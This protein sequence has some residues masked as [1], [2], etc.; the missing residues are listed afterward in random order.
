MWC[1]WRWR[2]TREKIICIK[3]L[4]SNKKQMST[5]GRTKSDICS[6]E[7]KQHACIKLGA[8]SGFGSIT[9]HLDCLR[10]GKKKI[11][12]EPYQSRRHFIDKGGNQKK[13]YW[14]VKRTTVVKKSRDKQTS[15][16]YLLLDEVRHEM[17]Q[18]IDSLRLCMEQR[19]SNQQLRNG[20]FR[21]VATAPSA[22]GGRMAT[23]MKPLSFGCGFEVGLERCCRQSR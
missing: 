12:Y 14:V 11:W 3:H 15:P 1:Y 23:Q 6:V 7:R 22:A 21:R 8:E 10:I 17:T 5:K 19:C 16:T 9:Y 18:P 13:K 4:V 20:A 2:K